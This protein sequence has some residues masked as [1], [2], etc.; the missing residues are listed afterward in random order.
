MSYA[1]PS[2]APV[3]FVKRHELIEVP[4]AVTLNARPPVEVPK[5][6][7]VYV[8]A[9]LASMT[10]PP[11]VMAVPLA[12]PTVAVPFERFTTLGVPENTMPEISI[13]ENAYCDIV[14]EALPPILMLYVPLP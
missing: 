10:L 12:I 6:F 8:F 7:P 9:G 1:S 11:T 13:L 5:E 3:W 4:V 2:I 14:V